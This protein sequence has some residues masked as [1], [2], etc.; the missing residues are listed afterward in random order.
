MHKAFVAATALLFVAPAAAFAHHSISAM[1]DREKAVS[2]SGRVTK[3]ELINPHAKIE[4]E[5]ANPRGEMVRWVLETGGPGRLERQGLT[6]AELSVGDTV[7][8]VGNPARSG[9]REAWL[10][11]L[12]T[13][14]R[15]FDMNFR[16]TGPAPTPTPAT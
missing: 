4:V 1:Y 11:Q 9:T 13:R 2:F 8:A 16:Q 15:T 7:K 10:T 12:Q 5:F 14:E 3:V 6:T